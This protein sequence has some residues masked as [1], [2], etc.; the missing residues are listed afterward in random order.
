MKQQEK[1]LKGSTNLN[2]KKKQKE[3]KKLEKEMQLA[4]KQATKAQQKIQQSNSFP[5]SEVSKLQPPPPP[6]N[7]KLVNF[8]INQFF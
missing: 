8:G 2:D 7:K 5:T 1:K 6:M 4:M 3:Q